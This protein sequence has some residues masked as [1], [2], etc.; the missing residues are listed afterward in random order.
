MKFAAAVGAAGY[1]HFTELNICLLRKVFGDDLDIVVRDDPS[2]DS[3]R[4]E[5]MA[6]KRGCFYRTTASPLGHFGGDM[7]TF[8]DALALAEAVDADIAIKVSQRFMLTSPAVRAIVQGRFTADPN[9]L[10]IMPG[11][12]NPNFIRQGHQQFARFPI[13]TDVVFMRADKQ[14]M[15]PEL[16]KGAYEEQLRKGS[17][18]V[19]SFIEVFWDRLRNGVLSGRVHLAP[20]LTDHKGGQ[21]P[22]FFRRY[23]NRADE[24]KRAAMQFGITAEPWELGERAKMT[25]GYN[26]VPRMV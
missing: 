5:R 16:L 14:T 22:V 11:R 3:A 8:L 1:G 17:S 19:D 9:L 23:Q 15:T 25:R 10:V 20:E 26:P 13:L 24:Y 4:I 12:P 6:D 21:P 2:P 18:Y 7:Q